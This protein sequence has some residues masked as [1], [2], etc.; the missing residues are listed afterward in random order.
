MSPSIWSAWSAHLARHDEPVRRIRGADICVTSAKLVW[1]YLL[2]RLDLGLVSVPSQSD[3]PSQPLSLNTLAG[4]VGM[5]RGSSDDLQH[6]NHC[7][8]EVSESERPKARA[9]RKE[10]Y[11][12]NRGASVPAPSQSPHPTHP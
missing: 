9:S 11:F 3:H 4:L 2:A 5:S 1:C 10:R 6:A 12:R 8:C 7:F